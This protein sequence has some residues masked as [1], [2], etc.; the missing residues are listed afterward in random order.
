MN[1][2]LKELKEAG[3]V[4]REEREAQELSLA[5]IQERTGISRSALCRLETD[6]EANPTVSTLLRI[7]NALDKKLL[8]TLID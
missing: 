4:L 5:D 7:A 2:V 6:L 3:R 1:A 8:I